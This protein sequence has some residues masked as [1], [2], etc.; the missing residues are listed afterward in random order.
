MELSV[1]EQLQYHR[2]TVVL[3]VLV[4]GAGLWHVPTV[5]RLGSAR[6]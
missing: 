5:D 3:S 2:W 6:A 1:H 4:L